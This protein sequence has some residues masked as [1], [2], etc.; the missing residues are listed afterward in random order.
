M[1][2]SWLQRILRPC[3][4]KTSKRMRCQRRNRLRRLRL[5]QL[6][7][8]W[9]AFALGLEQ[10][11]LAIRQKFP[12]REHDTKRRRPECQCGMN[13]AAE[14]SKHKVKQRPEWP[15]NI[16]LEW[17]ISHDAGLVKE[18]LIDRRSANGAGE[19]THIHSAHAT[20]AVRAF[21]GARCSCRAL[22]MVGDSAQGIFVELRRGV[23][24]AAC[25]TSPR[26]TC[27]MHVI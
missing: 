21:D 10:V 17:I 24:I 11:R 1:T 22:S 26:Q 12:D 18:R 6:W 14:D 3:S 15:D 5:P 4:L 7:R 27:A 19:R 20:P 23:C 25:V 16:L 13:D 9:Q 2:G 8:I